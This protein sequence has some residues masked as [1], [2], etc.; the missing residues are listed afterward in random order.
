MLLSLTA[1]QT[2]ALTFLRRRYGWRIK[3]EGDADSP[4]RVQFSIGQMLAWT[5]ATA[6]LLALATCVVSD[7][8]AV[9]R[10]L[11]RSQW[12]EA[13]IAVLLISALTLPLA[14][15]ATRLVVDDARRRRFATSFLL[16]VALIAILACSLMS[17]ILIAAGEDSLEAIL[18][19]VSVPAILFGFLLAMLGSLLVVRHCGFRLVRPKPDSESSAC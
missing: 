17:G 16:I 4:S 14:I 13:T 10:S 3:L 7:W 1:V 2:V 18:A 19:S 15:A 6:A 9:G 5:T 8:Q 11:R 12:V